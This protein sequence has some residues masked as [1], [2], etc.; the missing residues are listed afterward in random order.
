MKGFYEEH[1]ANVRIHLKERRR[2]MIQALNKYCA[3]IATWDILSGGFFIWL[4]VIPNIPMKKLFSEALSKG[5]L[6]NP[7]RIYEEKSDQY[8]RLSYG[9]ASPEQFTQGIYILSE[10]ISELME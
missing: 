10:L 3:D 7:G 8:I 4:R 5:I 6:L 1:V 2:I 9:Y